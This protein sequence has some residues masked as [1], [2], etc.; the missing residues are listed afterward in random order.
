MPLVEPFLALKVSECGDVGQGEGEAEL[1]FVSDQAEGEAAIFDAESAA[2]PVVGGLRGLVLKESLIEV[3]AETR[4]AAEAALLGL[5]VSEQD[6][7]L[8][9]VAL[10][11]DGFALGN[12]V[13]TQECV[14][15][16]EAERSV[17]IVYECGASIDTSGFQV[18]I[19]IPFGVGARACLDAQTGDDRRE[20]ANITKESDS[21]EVGGR[22]KYV[23]LSDN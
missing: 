20:A 19:E 16:A 10:A 5:P 8:V 11:G 22:G 4:R 7:E 3:E 21:G 17:A 15:A 1:I 13:G 9:K 12:I 14:S 18:V 23:A 6:S 2:I